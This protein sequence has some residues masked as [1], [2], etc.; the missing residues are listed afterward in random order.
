MVVSLIINLRESNFEE[1]EQMLYQASDPAHARYGQH[2]KGHEASELARPS[3]EAIDA[4]RNWLNSQGIDNSRLRY[5]R[6]MSWIGISL[7]ISQIET[8]LQANYST[9][10]HRDGTRLD[11]T[12]EYCLPIHLHEFVSTKQPTTCFLRRKSQVS[13]SNSRSIHSLTRK[14]TIEGEAVDKT[15]LCDPANVTP[16]FLRHFY[17]TFNYTARATKRNKMAVTNFLGAFAN[18]SDDKIYLQKYRPEAAAGAATFKVISIANGTIGQTPTDDSFIE[19]I[20]GFEGALDSQTILGMGWPTPLTIYSTA[21]T[22]PDFIPEGNSTNFD[23]PYVTWLQYMLSL[24]DHELPT[25]ISMSYNDDE[26]TVST[27]SWG[28]EKLQPRR[29]VRFPQRVVFNNLPALPHPPSPLIAD[30]IIAGSVAAFEPNAETFSGI[31]TYISGAGFSNIF[32]R[33][34]YQHSAVKA[35]LAANDSFPAYAGLFN[36]SGR[37]YPD[38][39]ASSQFFSFVYN[40]TVMH[41]QGTSASSPLVAGIFALVNDALLA[42]GRPPLGFLNPWLYGDGYKAF[43]DILEGSS[44]GCNTSGFPAAKGWDAVTGFG[45]PNFWHVLKALNVTI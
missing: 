11:R 8:L 23:E 44:A 4:V 9:F 1:L 40:A 37:A 30:K 25:V 2:L 19:Q 27:D 10:V 22:N 6:A 14:S 34:S 42:A 36:K 13:T 39:A 3:N 16:A 43:N 21:G 45:S 18:R 33:P 15:P 32:P 41:T 31:Q 7:P 20:L 28:Y 35:Y 38:L 24:P 17:G 29:R 26:Q 5:G 12:P